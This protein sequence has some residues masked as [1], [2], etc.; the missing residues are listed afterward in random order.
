MSNHEVLKKLVLTEDTYELVQD[1]STFVFQ[2]PREKNKIEIKKAVESAFG[3]KVKSVNTIVT[4]SKT[5][6]I[7]GQFGRKTRILGVKKA[8]VRIRE[9]DVS[10]IPLI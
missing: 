2:V 7:R 5:K 10:K 4:P 8:F 6:T 9:E 3:V 1:Q